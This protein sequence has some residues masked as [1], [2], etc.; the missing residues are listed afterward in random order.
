MLTA[1]DALTVVACVTAAGAMVEEA[2]KFLK[3]FEEEV[4]AVL[5]HDRCLKS[6]VDYPAHP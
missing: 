4:A 2:V 1:E 5:V 6:R 3:V